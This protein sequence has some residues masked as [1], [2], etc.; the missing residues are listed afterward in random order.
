ML[1]NYL[2]DGREFL[3]GNKFTIADICIAYALYLTPSARL[4]LGDGTPIADKY[5]PQVASYLERMTSRPAFLASR[6][7]QKESLAAFQKEHP[8]PSK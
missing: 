4:K 7:K 5:S 3:V 1:D 6:E 2:A 8:P